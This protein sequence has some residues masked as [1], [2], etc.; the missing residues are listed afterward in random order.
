MRKKKAIFLD[1]DG[2]LFENRLGPF[3]EDIDAI[4]EARKAG[5]VVFINTG[6]SLGNLPYIFAAAHYFDGFILG[7]GSHIICRGKTIYSAR[8]EPEKAAEISDFY[9]P[10]KKWCAFEG[11]S[12]IFAVHAAAL[13][14]FLPRI[15]A[16]ESS[17]DF[18]SKFKH[19][20]ITKLTIQGTLTKKEENF[21]SGSFKL[22]SFSRYFEGIIKGHD[23][24]GGIE[25]ALKELGIPRENTVAVG[26]SM[27]D[28][29]M[30]LGCGIGIAMGNAC[31][32]LKNAAKAVTRDCGKGGVGEAIRR[33]VL[34]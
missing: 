3:I 16:V 7:A 17:N 18:L 1:I 24:M 19:E 2:T 23:K 22:I 21:L 5:H 13:P 4:A 11:E 25:M 30:I 32:E 9:F 6:R 10:Q 34:S 26:D 28:M 15:T 8:I 29:D 20:R 14:L 12:G 27:N 31:D 33:Y